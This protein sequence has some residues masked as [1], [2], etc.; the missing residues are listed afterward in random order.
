MTFE[1]CSVQKLSPV[2]VEIVTCHW[3][4]LPKPGLLPAALLLWQSWQMQQATLYRVYLQGSNY[5]N[6]NQNGNQMYNRHQ[7][8][9]GPPQN[10]MW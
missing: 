1:L 5:G 7:Q 8:C 6:D 4:V 10:Q 2:F 3:S 9:I